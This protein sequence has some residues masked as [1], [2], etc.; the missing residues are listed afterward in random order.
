MPTL[1]DYI[2]LKIVFVHSGKNL[3][4]RKSYVIEYMIENILI[5]E[6]MKTKKVLTLMENKLSFV[7]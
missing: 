2:L 3:I 1:V 5:Y 4:Y 6:C 7:N